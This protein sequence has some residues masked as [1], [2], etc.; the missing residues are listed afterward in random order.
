MLENRISDTFERIQ[1]EEGFVKPNLVAHELS[2]SWIGRGKIKRTILRHPTEDYLY[3]GVEDV[4]RVFLENGDH[5]TI[6]TDDYPQRVITSGLGKLRK[7]LP[8]KERHRFTVT[9]GENKIPLLGP[10]F[11]R[12]RANGI[13]NVVIIDNS[14]D[15]L[16]QAK[17]VIKETGQGIAFYLAWINPSDPYLAS[18]ECFS[19]EITQLSVPNVHSL[20]QLRRQG[21]YGPVSWIIDFNETLVNTPAFM[22]GVQAAVANKVKKRR[23][24]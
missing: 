1:R 5:I 14:K 3:E 7:E 6:W 10:L 4:L 2:P 24:R 21:L 17:N 9:H 22:K 19:P 11:E 13:E 16:E 23:F 20:Q 18:P 15:N 12:T 8:Y